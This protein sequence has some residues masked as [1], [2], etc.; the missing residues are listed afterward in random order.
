M[1]KTMSYPPILTL[2]GHLFMIAYGIYCIWDRRPG[3][4][5]G[6]V[7]GVL[8]LAFTVPY[9]VICFR[10]FVWDN[11]SFVIYRLFRPTLRI[12]LAD[13]ADLR[14]DSGG[15]GKSYYRCFRI[16]RQGDKKYIDASGGTLTGASLEKVLAL[17]SVKTEFEN[18]LR[19]GVSFRIGSRDLRLEGDTLYVKDGS[20]HP[21][22]SAP[23]SSMRLSY[24]SFGEQFLHYDSL[25]SL[26]LGNKWRRSI[27]QALLLELPF[28][29][30]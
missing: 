29:R 7:C 10:W 17:P 16:L 27:W 21:E 3:E 8:L 15:V 20:I 12:P 14:E 30:Q 2:L 6:L 11:G 23:I 18:R 22:M 25:N 28:P 13:V 26:S 5:F 4:V 19:S 1:K 24:P 9:A